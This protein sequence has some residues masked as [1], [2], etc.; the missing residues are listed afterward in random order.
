[1]LRVAGVAVLALAAATPA[2]GR[3]APQSE[4]ARLQAEYRDEAVR[5]RR[6]KRG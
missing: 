6:S 5:A 3:R 2:A 4:L 1:M